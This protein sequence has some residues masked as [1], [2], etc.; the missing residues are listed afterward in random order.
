MI[1]VSAVIN[2]ESNPSPISSRHLQSFLGELWSTKAAEREF[3]RALGMTHPVLT[4]T[5]TG[6]RSG[7]ILA[8]THADQGFTAAK[9]RDLHFDLL[10]A[11]SERSFCAALVS[12]TAPIL[13]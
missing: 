8:K 9:L 6:W 3:L 5:E 7:R 12:P 11:L 13:K 1:S 10:I 4:P 2:R